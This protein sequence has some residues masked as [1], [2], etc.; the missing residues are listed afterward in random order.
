MSKKII[1]IVSYMF[2]VVYYVILFL[3]CVEVIRILLVD[4]NVEYEE[5]DV[6]F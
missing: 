2:S 4:N 3:G 5:V 6:G 1:F